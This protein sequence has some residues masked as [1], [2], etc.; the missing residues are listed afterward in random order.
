M[1][2]LARENRIMVARAHGGGT[3]MVLCHSGCATSAYDCLGDVTRHSAL[4]GTTRRC[5]P[6]PRLER[7]CR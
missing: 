7:P 6:P 3:I 2:R 1:A 4:K 5:K